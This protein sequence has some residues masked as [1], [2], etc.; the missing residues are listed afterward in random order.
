LEQSSCFKEL[1]PIL[2]AIEMLPQE[3]NGH[4]VVINTDNLS[5]V[6]AIIKGSCQSPDL[7][8]LLFTITELAAERNL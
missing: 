5:N 6:Y 7:Y 4:I 1:V 2:L 3:A 8:E